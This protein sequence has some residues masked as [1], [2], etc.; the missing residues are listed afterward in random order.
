MARMPLFEGFAVDYFRFY[1]SVVDNPKL[2]TLPPE[3]YRVWTFLLCLASRRLDRGT[4][5]PIEELPF[6]LHMWPG[7]DDEVKQH[8]EILVARKLVIRGKGD[9]LRIADWEVYQPLEPKS[10]L[11]VRRHRQRAK[12]AEETP[13]ESPQTAE[14][15]HETFHETPCNVSETFLKRGETVFIDREKP[16]TESSGFCAALQSLNP[17]SS[18]SP[19]PPAETTTTTGDVP[20]DIWQAVDLVRRELGDRAA[21]AVEVM[22]EVVDRDVAGRWDCFAA[23]VRAARRAATTKP[24]RDVRVYLIRLTKQFIHDGIPPEPVEVAVSPPARAD[25]AA[26][27]LDERKRRAREAMASWPELQD[28]D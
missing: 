13:A 10:T 25:P 5:P 17:P 6:E 23:A 24:I 15:H 11:R 7:R 19:Q 22:F 18:A 14:P 8:I 4:L 27:S 26:L 3:T 20:G 28:G 1:H 12:Q 16:P 9:S 2:H 21:Q